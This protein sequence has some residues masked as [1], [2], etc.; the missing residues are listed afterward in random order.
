MSGHPMPTGTVKFQVQFGTGAW[1]TFSTKTLDMNGHA[2]SDRYYPSVAG[3]YHFRAIYSGDANY[4]GS[5]SGDNAEHLTV[6][7][8]ANLNACDHGN[9]AVE[10]NMANCLKKTTWS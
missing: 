2:T 8:N 4:R 10:K 6:R 5:Q 9:Y 7:P 3:S 1:I